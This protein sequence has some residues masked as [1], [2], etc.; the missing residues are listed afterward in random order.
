VIRIAWVALLVGLAAS[1]VSG[2]NGTVVAIA[3]FGTVGLFAWSLLSGR[4]RLTCPYCG[5]RVKLGHATC[6]HCGRDVAKPR[7]I[8][9]P[10]HNPM[11]VVKECLACKSPIRPDATIC[12]HCRTTQDEPWVLRDGVW[13]DRDASGAAVWYDQGSGQWVRG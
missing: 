11:Q 9:A 13:W 4:T 2:G 12:P 7:A 8:G 3:I 5:K 10:R 1:F 6:H